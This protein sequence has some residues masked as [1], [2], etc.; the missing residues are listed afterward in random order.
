MAG[1]V[2][3]VILTVTNINQSSLEKPMLCKVHNCTILNTKEALY[4]HMHV[5]LTHARKQ[6]AEWCMQ[7][8]AIN[9]SAVGIIP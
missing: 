9:S 4:D 7:C 6:R 2:E 1:Y 3:V 5:M 8:G